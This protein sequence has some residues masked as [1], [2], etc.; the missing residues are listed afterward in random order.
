MKRI[1]LFYQYVFFIVYKRYVKIGEK[2]IPEIYSVG[3][4]T[5]LQYFALL[6]IGV[7]II[8]QTAL[9]IDFSKIY[10]ALFGLALLGVNYYLF[11]IYKTIDYVTSLFA[12]STKLVL[13]KMAIFF[14]IHIIMSASLMIVA[15]IL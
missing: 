9:V 13:N 5:L 12:N 1:F 6:G 15:S 2:D 11:C 10:Y 3:V 8:K 7:I 4:V 14:V